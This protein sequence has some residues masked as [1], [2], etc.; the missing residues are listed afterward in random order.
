[1]QRAR[2]SALF[3]RLQALYAT[4]LSFVDARVVIG[5]SCKPRARAFKEGNRLSQTI[6]ALRQPLLALGIAKPST[7]VTQG[8][9]MLDKPK[10]VSGVLRAP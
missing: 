7:S 1:M 3:H 9:G 2:T 4:R 8:H 10:S 5:A 6:T